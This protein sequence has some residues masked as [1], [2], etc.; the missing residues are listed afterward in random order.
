MSRRI[1]VL[2]PEPENAVT[3]ARI[4][5]LGR[6]ALRL[7]LFAVAPVAW[8]VPDPRRYDSLLLTSANALRHAGAG[9]AALRSL[10][11]HAVGAATAV[12]A[13]A[14]GF[15]VVAVGSGGVDALDPPGR[16]LRLAGREH[17]PLAGADTIVVYA[18]DALAPDLSPLVG[19]IAMIHSPRAGQALAGRMADRSRVDIVAI[20]AAAAAA[21]GPGWRSVAVADR[22]TDDAII[23]A[24]LSLG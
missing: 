16:I 13:R 4:A 9:L 6:T 19:S 3:A 5:A 11:V 12:A 15:D 21:A 17:R 23:A 24:T 8:D 14:A 2:R 20:S 22:P 18:S 10:P 1:A 7:P